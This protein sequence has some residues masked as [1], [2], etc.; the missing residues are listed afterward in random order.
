MKAL[1]SWR[2][3]AILLAQECGMLRVQIRYIVSFVL[4]FFLTDL[5][6]LDRQTS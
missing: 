4:D 1:G 3:I 2:N 5:R 6:V